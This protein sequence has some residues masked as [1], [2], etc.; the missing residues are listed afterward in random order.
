MYLLDVPDVGRDVNTALHAVDLVLVVRGTKAPPAET[1]HTTANAAAP[2]PAAAM[3]NRRSELAYG[4]IAR[5]LRLAADAD[6]AA[7]D[8]IRTA[9][10]D[11][12]L[13]MTVPTVKAAPPPPPAAP[14]ENPIA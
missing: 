3:R 1:N 6:A 7:T 5:T 13:T 2:T 14:K 4:T 11:G 9:V 12:V 8:R 10:K